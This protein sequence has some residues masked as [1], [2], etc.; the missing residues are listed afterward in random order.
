M[1]TAARLIDARAEDMAQ[2][3]MRKQGKPLA[4]AR[5]E[6]ARCAET[7]EVCATEAIRSYGRVHPQWASSG[8]Q[9]VLK[10]PIG[11]VA[12]FTAWSFPVVLSGRKLAATLGAG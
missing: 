9:M 2:Q 3:L 6:L 5:G 7:F 10:E 8:R 1:R 12:A 4:E 11:P